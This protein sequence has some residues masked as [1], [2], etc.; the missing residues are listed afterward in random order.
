M[1]TNAEA[2]DIQPGESRAVLEFGEF[3]E[4]PNA[5][6]AHPRWDVSAGS[7][8]RDAVALVDHPMSPARD[9]LEGGIVWGELAWI[10]FAVVAG[11]SIV[12]LGVVIVQMLKELEDSGNES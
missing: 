3:H 8:V 6:L 12:G 7:A 2:N 4:P 9:L 11:L 5:S 1:P 10:I